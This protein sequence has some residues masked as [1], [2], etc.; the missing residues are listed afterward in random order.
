[1]LNV[2]SK[3]KTL[4]FILLYFICFS[5]SSIIAM[6]QP[7]FIKGKRSSNTDYFQSLTQSYELNPPLIYLIEVYLQF[8]TKNTHCIN[9]DSETA[10]Q[11]LIKFLLRCQ[12]LNQMDF[13]S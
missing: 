2:V 12:K 10:K 9:C 4:L 7:S 3:I 1:S 13:F 11:V 8:Q 6:I 5:L